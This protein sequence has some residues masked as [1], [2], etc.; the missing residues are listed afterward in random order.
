VLR[1]ERGRRYGN[2]H[3]TVS[4]GMVQQMDIVE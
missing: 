4:D 2:V 3:F 1:D